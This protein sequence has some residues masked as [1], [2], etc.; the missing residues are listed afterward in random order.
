M[1]HCLS[2]RLHTLKKLTQTHEVTACGCLFLSLLFGVRWSAA[3]WSEYSPAVTLT[4]PAYESTPPR[5]WIMT[6]WQR[7]L[8][9]CHRPGTVNT[10]EGHSLGH[11]RKILNWEFLEEHCVFA[12]FLWDISANRLSSDRSTERVILGETLASRCWAFLC[13]LWTEK[14][15]R[16]LRHPFVL[17]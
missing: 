3:L 11:S 14:W 8:Q 9:G 7:R 6:C 13:K 12:F 4:A 15:W 5:V 17:F 1:H 10:A 16:G 2:R